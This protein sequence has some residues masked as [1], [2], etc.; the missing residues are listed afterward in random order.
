MPALFDAHTRDGGGIM[1]Y[2]QSGSSSPS[3]GQTLTF[4]GLMAVTFVVSS[5]KCSL[6]RAP[7]NKKAP[8]LGGGYIAQLNSL[9]NFKKRTR[10][11]IPHWLYR[12]DQLLRGFDRE[13]SRSVA[14]RKNIN[15]FLVSISFKQTDVEA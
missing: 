9:G 3:V 15:K 11:L 13:C 6:G 4:H 7:P 14:K 12:G 1:L 8:C 10:V 5:M 2:Q